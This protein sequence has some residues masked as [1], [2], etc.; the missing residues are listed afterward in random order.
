MAF[1]IQ[2]LLHLS[3]QLRVS[4]LLLTHQPDPAWIW[5]RRLQAILIRTL[6]VQADDLLAPGLIMSGMDNLNLQEIELGL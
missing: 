6:I 1:A 5:R 3:G 4:L 2:L